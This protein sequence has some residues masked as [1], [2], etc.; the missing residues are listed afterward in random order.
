MWW[1]AIATPWPLYPLD[2]D[3]VPVVQ[4][5]WWATGPVWMVQKISPQPGYD[6]RTVQS[7]ATIPT[8][9]YA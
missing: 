3:P 1:L 8:E 2:R 7:V 6:P 5:S 4:E 9:L